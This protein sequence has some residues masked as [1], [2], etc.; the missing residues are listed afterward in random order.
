MEA[1]R[2]E[3]SLRERALKKLASPRGPPKHVVGFFLVRSLVVA[4]WTSRGVADPQ[5]EDVDTE[6]EVE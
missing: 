2:Q 5:S 4:I 3:K 1:L 6:E